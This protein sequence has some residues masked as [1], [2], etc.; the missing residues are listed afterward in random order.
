MSQSRREFSRR[1]LLGVG[2]ALTATPYLAAAQAGAD[3]NPAPQLSSPDIGVSVLV[4]A[5][6]AVGKDGMAL[7]M[8]YDIKSLTNQSHM[9]IGPA[10]T[11]EWQTGRGRMTPEDVRRNMFDPLDQAESGSVW[12]IAGGGGKLVSL[13]GGIIGAAC[14]R[15]GFTGA[16]TD[17]GCRDVS[18]FNEVGFPVFA[19][20]AVPYG[21][22]DFARPVDANVPVTCGGVQVRPGD[23]I[24]ADADGI[25]VIPA[26]VHAD[27]FKAAEEILQKEQAVMDKIEAGEKLAD[28]YNL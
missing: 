15:M 17:N 10:V 11:T 12:V 22:A 8:A 4:D 23:T 18:T 21:P 19:K 13:F 27:V 5:L 9:V 6:K 20:S 7:T 25:V 24:A 1:S 16:I 3:A 14:K 2:A 28:A 26:E